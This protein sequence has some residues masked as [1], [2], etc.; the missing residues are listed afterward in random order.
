MYAYLHQKIRNDEHCPYCRKY[1]LTVFESSMDIPLIYEKGNNSY[2]VDEWIRR[3]N[4]DRYTVQPINN[5]IN[6]D[7]NDFENVE[8]EEI[9]NMKSK[10]MLIHISIDKEKWCPSNIK[11]NI[12]FHENINV[13]SCEIPYEDIKKLCETK[14]LKI[15]EGSK[16]DYYKI[17]EIEY[18][19]EMH[20]DGSELYNGF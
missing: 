20:I 19:K 5:N 10:M 16:L 8:C 4:G 12:S 1:Y 11:Y 7:L 17:I 13:S 3:R 2:W 6:Y 18:G 14:E 9:P 15:I